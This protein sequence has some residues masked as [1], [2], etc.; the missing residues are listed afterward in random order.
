MAVDK[1][2]FVDEEE[3]LQLLPTVL[4]GR[5]RGMGGGID[6]Y[7]RPYQHMQWEDEDFHPDTDWQDLFFGRMSKYCFVFLSFLDFTQPQ[8]CFSLVARSVGL[9][10]SPSLS[11]TDKRSKDSRGVCLVLSVK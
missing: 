2:G 11:S 1:S 4:A 7:R 8:T 10:F 5:M 6:F 3:F 9:H